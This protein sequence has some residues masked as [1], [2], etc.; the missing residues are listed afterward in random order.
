MRKTPSNFG[1]GRILN[2]RNKKFEKYRLCVIKTYSVLNKIKIV[3]KN[4]D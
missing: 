3:D 1:L 4:N 2:S